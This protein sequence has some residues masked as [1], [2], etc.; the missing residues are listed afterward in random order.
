MADVLATVAILLG[1]MTAWPCLVIWFS[2]AFPARVAAARRRLDQS[3]GTSAGLGAVLTLVV[4][5]IGLVLLQAPRAPIKMMGWALIVLL[6]LLGT[7]GG[8]AL[9][10]LMAE[11]VRGVSSPGS[12]L[13]SLVRAAL[14]TELA[15]LFPVVGWFFFLPAILLTGIGAGVAALRGGAEAEAP[16]PVRSPTA[17]PMGLDVETPPS[18]G[19]AVSQVS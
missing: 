6:L 1:L 14:L 15:A 7:L 17:A 18:V 2:L 4:G 16:A 5:G 19:E 11:R 3:P 10:E 13:R 8:A 12:P 9:V